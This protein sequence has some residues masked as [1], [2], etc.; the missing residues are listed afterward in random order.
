[1][2]QAVL[3]A[4]VGRILQRPRQLVLQQVAKSQE[5]CLTCV[6]G[7]LV[8]MFALGLASLKGK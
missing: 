8:D 1:M 4:P 3:L 2:R 6:C 5:A 7:K